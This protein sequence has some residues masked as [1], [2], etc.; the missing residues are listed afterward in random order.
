VTGG[1]TTVTGYD[2]HSEADMGL[3]ALLAFWTGGDEA[4]IDR[5]FRESGLMREKWD[6]RHFADGRTYGGKAIERV[7]AGTT[8]F[9][10]SAQTEAMLTE[11]DGE[12]SKVDRLH[13]LISERTTGEVYQSRDGRRESCPR[14]S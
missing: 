4:Q 11:R 2:S 1:K 6:E 12:R 7:L 3:C 5:R 13:T 10:E 9:Y 8:E 14:V